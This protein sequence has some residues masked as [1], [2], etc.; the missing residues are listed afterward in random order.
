MSCLG[1]QSQPVAELRISHSKAA[2]SGRLDTPTQ[3]GFDPPSPFSPHHSLRD[4]TPPHAPA[5]RSFLQFLQG[6]RLSPD[7]RPLP[8][9][10]LLPGKP[11]PLSVP[12]TLDN[13]YTSLNSEQRVDVASSK[14]CPLSSRP[15]KPGL[16]GSLWAPPTREA[17]L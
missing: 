8:M 17:P 7:S 5:T 3:A 15:M 1:S 4:P 6:A 13:S 11:S 16:W 2:V 12:W 10:L 9:L 14:T